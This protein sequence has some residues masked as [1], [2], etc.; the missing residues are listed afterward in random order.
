ML[1]SFTLELTVFPLAIK[2]VSIVEYKFAPAMVIAV[3]ELAD[4][5]VAILP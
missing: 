4:I 3:A 2:F 5:V 1:S